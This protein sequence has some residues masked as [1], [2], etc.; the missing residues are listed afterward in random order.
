[1][2]RAGQDRAPDF[3]IASLWLSIRFFAR[4]VV[5]FIGTAMRNIAISGTWFSDIP[6][7]NVTTTIVDVD[8][9]CLWIASERLNADADTEIH[10]YKKGLPG[11]SY[12]VENVSP[13]LEDPIP[14]KFIVTSDSTDRSR[15]KACIVYK[16]ARSRVL[17][18][19]SFAQERC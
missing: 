12:E 10:I 1:M 8:R 7:G 14:H 4:L 15:R 6:G 18:A 17:L 3:L 13:P 11:D 9:G 5:R 19:S 16:S 2:G